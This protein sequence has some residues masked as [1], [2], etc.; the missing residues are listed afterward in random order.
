MCA[1]VCACIR[2][3]MYHKT[4]KKLLSVRYEMK[5]VVQTGTVSFNPVWVHVCVCVYVCVCVC[6]C[7][8]VPVCVCV[9]V[10]VCACVSVCVCV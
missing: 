1:C 8:C 7:A 10:F 9:C 6:V 3:S 2:V 4:S 5:F